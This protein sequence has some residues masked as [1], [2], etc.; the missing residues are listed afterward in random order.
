MLGKRGGRDHQSGRD[1]FVSN[2]PK[3]VRNLG[4]FYT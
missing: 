2:Y 4:T 3:L 1:V